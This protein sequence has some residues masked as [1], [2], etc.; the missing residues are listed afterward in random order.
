MFV[1]QLKTVLML[2]A[3]QLLTFSV[4]TLISIE[5]KMFPLNIFYYK[6]DNYCLFVINL[7]CWHSFVFSF[8]FSCQLGNWPSGC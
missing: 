7:V 4:G 2:D 3:L 6:Q 8:F 1:L 5:D